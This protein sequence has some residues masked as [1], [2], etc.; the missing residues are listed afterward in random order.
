MR[1]ISI[2][3]EF[4]RTNKRQDLFP[5]FKKE[6]VV[7][8]QSDGDIFSVSEKRDTAI[9]NYLDSAQKR[10]KNSQKISAASFGVL[11]LMF[12]AYLF[13]MNKMSGSQKTV[14][15]ITTGFRSLKD[16]KSIPTL[17]SCNSLSK[18]MRDYLHSQLMYA[19]ASP[20]ELK[21]AG[22]TK[23][24]NRLLLYGPPGTGKTYF[25][26]IF[27][28]T[29]DAEYLEI[30]YSDLNHKFVGHHL[31]NIKNAFDSVID[32]ASK[33]KDK[34]YVVTFNEIDAIIV[35]QQSLIEGGGGHVSFKLEERNVFLN[36]LD[37][38]GEK[39]PNVTVIG[40]TN[41]AA[42]TEYLDAAAISRFNDKIMVDYPDKTLLRE[43]LTT[44]LKEFGGESFINAHKDKWD[45]FAESLVKRKF[46]FRDLDYVIDSSKRFHFADYLNDKSAKF[47]FEYLEKARNLRD[48]TDGEADGLVEFY[49]HN[50][51]I[52]I[53]VL[54]LVRV[55][56]SIE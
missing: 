25:A 11:G 14:K 7:Q 8:T 49:L 37:E 28:K 47:K 5:N 34:R 36:Y 50:S 6:G 19:K 4:A 32:V 15:Q 41:R 31:D 45:D 42:K 13:Y 12:A 27:A 2:N 56:S 53:F 51:R 46:S 43:A 54:S 22:I 20:D 38:I 16:D 40:T 17:E 26:K 39:V 30:K 48:V 9:I 1:V 21:K 55:A 33:N 3:N 23:P 24:S 52:L 18:K 29:T 35:P 44:H 10:D